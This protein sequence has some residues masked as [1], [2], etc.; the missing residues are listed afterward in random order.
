MIVESPRK[1]AEAKKKM[2]KEALRKNIAFQALNFLPLKSNFRQRVIHFVEWKW[3]DL[4]IIFLIV[5]NSVF[6]GMVDYTDMEDK[7]FGN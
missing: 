3:F 4:I 7:S 6:L 5:L 2:L 1:L